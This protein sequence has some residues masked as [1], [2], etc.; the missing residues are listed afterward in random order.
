[1]MSFRH[2]L[3]GLAAVAGLFVFLS[4]GHGAYDA[5]IQSA[6]GAL[7]VQNYVGPAMTSPNYD[8]NVIGIVYIYRFR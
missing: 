1:M 5:Y 8:V 2:A 4:T 3:R 7:A 6:L